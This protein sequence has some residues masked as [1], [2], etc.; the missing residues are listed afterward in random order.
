MRRTRKTRPGCHWLGQCW[1]DGSHNDPGRPG[2]AKS[3]L[4]AVKA[5]TMG[6]LRKPIGSAIADR[7]FGYVETVRNSGP[8][9]YG[10]KEH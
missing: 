3:H 8:Y 10:L 5:K 4:G 2:I 7:A 6:N 9:F 1:K